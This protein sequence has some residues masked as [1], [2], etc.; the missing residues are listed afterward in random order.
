[1]GVGVHTAIHVRAS[2]HMLLLT[3]ADDD[4]GASEGAAAAAAAAAACLRSCATSPTKALCALH[5]R[6]SG[7]PAPAAG[8]GLCYVCSVIA[9]RTSRGPAIKCYA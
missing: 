6:T 2:K 8:G 7:Q 5:A 9:G 3:G 4:A 1:M